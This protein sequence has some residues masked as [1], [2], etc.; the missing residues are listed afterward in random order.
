M[1]RKSDNIPI[2]NP[3]LDKRVK[4]TDEQREEIRREYSTGLIS[5]RQ[6]AEKYKVSKRLI[7]FTIAPEKKKIAK[8]QF[9]ERQSDGRYYNKEKHRVYTKKHRDYKKELWKS[10]LL[11]NPEKENP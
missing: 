5:Q 11:E 6:L 1:P 8:E 3:K 2:N 9:A 4:L 7:Q 10:E